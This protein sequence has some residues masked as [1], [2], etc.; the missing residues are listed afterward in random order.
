MTKKPIS[1]NFD[2]PRDVATNK[3]GNVLRSNKA[4]NGMYLMRKYPIKEAKNAC[5]NLKKLF[6]RSGLA[7]GE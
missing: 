1:L 5:K 6:V 7:L 2:P 3:T 4:Q